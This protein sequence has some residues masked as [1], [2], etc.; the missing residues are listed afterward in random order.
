MKRLLLLRHA[1]AVQDS[2]DG[3]HARGLTRR[4]HNDSTQMGHAMDIRGYIPDLAYASTALRTVETWQG[5]APELR[6]APKIE[7]LKALY[8]ASPKQILSTVREAPDASNA[9]L[10]VGHNPGIAD[11]AVRLARKPQSN[12][13]NAFRD[14]MI[15]KF[16]TAALAVLEFDV[17][18]WSK[19]ALGEGAL[20]EFIRPMDLKS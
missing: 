14:R 17:E 12:E 20:A 15:E 8:L 2:E 5:V 4:G 10:I 13:E 11:I 3:D 6:K 19:I 18:S 16:P 7:F 1:K 9:L